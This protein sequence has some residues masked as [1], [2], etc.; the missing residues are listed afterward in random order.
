M[1][2]S[3][4]LIVLATASGVALTYLIVDDEPMLWRL[5]TGNVIGCA[6]YG[7]VS[8]VAGCLFG[9]SGLIA[10]ISLILTLLPLVLFA[11]KERLARLRLDWQ[12]A[13]GKLQGANARK[14][15][16]FSFYLFFFILFWL[17][18]ERAMFELPD[19]IYTGGSHNLGDLPF[20]LGAIYSFTDGNN[21]PPQNPS[22][23]GA[24]FSYPFIADLLTACFMKMGTGVREAMFAQNFSWALSLLVVL[25][26]FVVRLTGERSAGKI[27]AFILFFCGGLGFIWFLSDFWAQ[28]NGFWDFLRHMPR[29]YTMGDDFS[30]G[31]S[32]ITLFITQRSLLLGMPLTIIVLGFLWKAFVAE[33]AGE[34]HTDDHG[35]IVWPAFWI[36]LIA[37][38]LPLIHL[39]S[40]VVL[41]VVTGFLFISKPEHWRTW[42]SFGAAVCIIAVPELI[43]SVTGSA[44]KATEFFGWH[45]GWDAKDENIIWFWIRN[46]G[47]L[48]PL[49]IAGIFA[50]YFG[51]NKAETAKSES[52]TEPSNKPR[53]LLLFYL[54]FIFCFIISNL[55]KLAPWEWDN[56]KV[57]IYWFLG[58]LPFATMA[59]LWAWR[60]NTPFKIAA[61]ICFGALIASGSLDVW[62]TV[63]NQVKTKVFE[64]DGKQVAEQ[65]KKTTPA[66]AIF[67]NAPTYNSAIVLSG[68]ISLMRF[69]GHLWSHG[70]DY[71]QR[72]TDVKM[73]YAGESGADDLLRNYGVD[74][75]LI[76][77]DERNS[78]KVNDG[79][80]QRF[81]VVSQVGQ[82]RVYKIK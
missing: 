9:L 51:G 43:W 63:S 71:A 5:A 46:T 77:P 58:S 55:A 38:C 69:P 2:L 7:T 48:I 22:F 30:W 81:P 4:F 79:F 13:K 74:Y 28:A 12:R 82:Y 57:L 61:A 16:T 21:F 1:I 75:V 39:H 50:A 72:E 11:K 35:V 27:A 26:R 67:L 56:I 15:I 14:F 60:K 19:G 49:I 44:S 23:A 52:P 76:S 10:L 59:I 29:D 78:L 40:L 62:R 68:R 18:F 8:F 41:F 6:V 33:N 24:R 45:F 34:N 54:P 42:L 80:F 53:D 66:N 17:F 65:I 47:L 73:I 3:F 31:N 37:G 25:D 64:K 20:H 32:L 70:I 36:G